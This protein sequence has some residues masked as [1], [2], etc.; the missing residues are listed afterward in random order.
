MEW[1]GDTICS[2]IFVGNAI[3]ISV[4]LL[5]RLRLLQRF[6]D[7]ADEIKRLLGHAV[8]LAV[9]DLLEALDGVGDRH[10]LALETRELRGDEER[11]RQEL[12]DLAGARHG[13]LVFFRQLVDAEN[14]D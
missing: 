6:L 8:V 4:R 2:W 7:R 10:V 11:L 13:L 9:D 1:S 3:V 5:K 12:L 14:R